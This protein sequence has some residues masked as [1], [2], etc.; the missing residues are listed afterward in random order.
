MMYDLRHRNEDIQCKFSNLKIKGSGT[1]LFSIS[2]DSPTYGEAIEKVSIGVMGRGED[3]QLNNDMVEM[4]EARKEQERLIQEYVYSLCSEGALAVLSACAPEVAVAA[5]L[6]M[7]AL[8]GKAGSISG[9][10]AFLDGNLQTTAFGI[11]NK[12]ASDT[13]NT[14][15]N[16]EAATQNMNAVNYKV[17]MEMMGSGAKYDMVSA[18]A[19]DM[20]ENNIAFI[21]IYNPDVLRAINYWNNNGVAGWSGWSK[22]E[23]A[24]IYTELIKD[25][26]IK[27]EKENNYKYGSAKYTYEEFCEQCKKILNGGIIF[28]DN[29]M[30]MELF[31]DAIE[32]IKEFTGVNL[33]EEFMEWVKNERG[34]MPEDFN[35]EQEVGQ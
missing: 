6:M 31:F 24:A 29:E 9:T 34:Y 14:I 20:T 15:A 5:S 22:K 3:V 1:A 25:T 16:L 10:K 4:S 27:E 18:A 2:H 11:A 28:T 26:D 8:E 17:L 21:G 13:I 35:L 32:E 7:M 12:W 23:S 33:R 19:I 30:N